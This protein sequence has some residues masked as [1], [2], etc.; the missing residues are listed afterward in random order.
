MVVFR[1]VEEGSH[2]SVSY[3]VVGGTHATPR[4]SVSELTGAQF[5]G[6]SG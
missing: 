1:R 3:E 4:A 2:W 6:A 5:I